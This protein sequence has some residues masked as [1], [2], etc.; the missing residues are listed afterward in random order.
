MTEDNYSDSDQTGMTPNRLESLADA[1]FAFAMTLLVLSINVPEGG[2]GDI[3]QFIGSQYRNLLTAFI[4]FSLLA[5]FWLTFSQAFHHI[6]KTDSVMLVLTIFML[7][8]VIVV[9]FF[10]TL[11]NDY[12]DSVTAEIFFNGNL[13]ILTCMMALIWIY[14]TRRGMLT[15]S[16]TSK[17][18]I[19][20]SRAI[21]LLPT[22]P[23]AA[24]ILSLMTPGWSAM[25]Y[26]LIPAL[27]FL[28]LLRG[29]K[30]GT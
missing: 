1:I 2:V 4:S 6:R 17:H 3:G 9:P 18:I 14:V 19:L 15:E 25:V 10:T 30:S 28:P 20:A 16:A 29:R 7:F 26:L 5:F 8:F 21:K 24:T 27:I 13:L 11:M 12:P 22:I 23:L